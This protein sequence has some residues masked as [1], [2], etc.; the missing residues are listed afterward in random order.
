MPRHKQPAT[1]LADDHANDETSRSVIAKWRR[2]TPDARNVLA[3]ITGRE[4]LAAN[5][6]K[7]RENRGLS[8]AAVATR[9]TAS[10]SDVSGRKAMANILVVTVSFL[11]R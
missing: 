6:R 9:P 8:Q 3:R 1:S 2:L 5:L 4:P 10:D 7:A 11:R